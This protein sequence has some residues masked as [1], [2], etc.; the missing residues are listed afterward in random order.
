M[1]NILPKRL[2][3]EEK[4]QIIQRLLIGEK[5]ELLSKEF[6]V[7]KVTINRNL[8]KLLG[9]TE[10]EKLSQKIKVKNKLN[11]IKGPKSSIK[12][13]KYE[14]KEFNISKD[15]ELENCENFTELTPLLLDIDNEP[16]KDLTSIDIK[17]FNFPKIVYMI[18]NKKI[19]L[20]TKL[21]KDYPEWK[22]LSD[23]DLNR[24][25]FEIFFDIKL[26][27]RACHREQKVI[28]VPNPEVFKLVAPILLERGIT[29]IIGED[30]LIA[31]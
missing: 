9:S 8:K 28:K 21:L 25:T 23:N 3:E 30:K 22:F 13:K 24:R 16:Q 26:A 2:T 10:F 11:V 29:R 12:L 15:M 27:K 17:S 1:L 14:S 5:I 7:T 19:E 31:L 20:E 18:V 6:G 4:H